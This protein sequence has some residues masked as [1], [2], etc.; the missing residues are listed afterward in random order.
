MPE[1]IDVKKSATAAGTATQIYSTIR[2]LLAQRALET[3]LI[4]YLHS[5]WALL[6]FIMLNGSGVKIFTGQYDLAMGLHCPGFANFSFYRYE[7]SRARRNHCQTVAL[8][9]FGWL[10]SLHS[11]YS[12]A[13]VFLS[14]KQKC[15]RVE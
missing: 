9:L 7:P 15:L 11:F 13:L 5:P 1:E 4:L 2:H 8:S 6:S 3:L 10:L 14:L 12:L